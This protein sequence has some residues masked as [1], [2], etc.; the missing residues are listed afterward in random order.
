[1]AKRKYIFRV[2]FYKEEKE[3]IALALE[4][5]L[6]GYGKTKPAALKE[7]S[8][9]VA[10]QETFAKFKNQIEL[11]WFPAEEKYWRKYERKC[12]KKEK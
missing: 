9:L 11:V 8:Q 5:D 7:L 3:W 12:R 2:L 1:M 4:M 10:S 6:R